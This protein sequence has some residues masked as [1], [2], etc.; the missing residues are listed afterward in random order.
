MR[1]TRRIEFIFAT[2]VLCF[3]ALGIA[4]LTLPFL[5]DAPLL[6]SAIALPLSGGA[7]SASTF[8]L[9]ATIAVS[10]MRTRSEIRRSFEE[11]HLLLTMELARIRRL[12]EDRGA[13]KE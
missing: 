13:D 1:S 9:L 10:I 12:L 8:F 4:L 2:L 11:I 5:A 3:F 7:F 6:S